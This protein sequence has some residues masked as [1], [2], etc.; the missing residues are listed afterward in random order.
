MT[1]V[2][3]GFVAL[4][5][6]IPSPLV[7]VGE[8]SRDRLMLA[9]AAIM[10]GRTPEDVVGYLEDGFPAA[11]YV[12]LSRPHMAAEVRDHVSVLLCAM[13]SPAAAG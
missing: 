6:A 5:V 12:L 11:V 13:Q 10:L 3:D 4:D 7:D 9:V 1:A 8:E 2:L